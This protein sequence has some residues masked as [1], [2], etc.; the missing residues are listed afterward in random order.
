ML[1]KESSEKSKIKDVTTEQIIFCAYKIHNELGPGFSEKIYHNA[2][3]MAL[4]EAGLN[5][6]DEKEYKVIYQKRKV[7]ILRLDLIVQNEVVVEIKAVIGDMPL[8]FEAQT[9]SYLKVTGCR[10]GLLINFG[11][12]SCHIRRLML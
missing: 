12:R 9:L 8:V 6:E 7:G 2:L 5:Y 10:V 4:N 3:R 1:K 11:N